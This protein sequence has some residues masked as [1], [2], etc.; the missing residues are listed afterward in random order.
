M[1]NHIFIDID[2]ERER[3]IIF[4]KPPDV[5]PPEN[6]E[7]AGKMILNDIA[8]L[9]EAVTTLILMAEQNGYGDKEKLIKAT[10]DTINQLLEETKPTQDEL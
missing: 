5:A 1:T 7:E 9:A 2:T 6:K 4:G 10:V 8:C 3:P